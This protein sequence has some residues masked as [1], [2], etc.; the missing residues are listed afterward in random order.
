MKLWHGT[1]RFQMHDVYWTETKFQNLSCIFEYLEPMHLESF[2]WC[3]KSVSETRI[4]ALN[5]GGHRSITSSNSRHPV[6]QSFIHSVSQSFIHSVSQSFIHS[7]S[8]SFSRYTVCFLRAPYFELPACLQCECCE[9]DTFRKCSGHIE[10]Y[11]RASVSDLLN[12]AR[13]LYMSSADLQP[14]GCF[15][16]YPAKSESRKFQTLY[17][18]RVHPV[19]TCR[20]LLDFVCLLC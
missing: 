3:H 4:W 14:S 12:E 20:W 6:S 8:Q 15:R 18:D 13:Y 17:F 16:I 19:K 11:C 1:I 2:S 10:I 7:V 9:A 5:I